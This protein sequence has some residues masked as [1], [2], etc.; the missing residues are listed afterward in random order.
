[1]QESTQSGKRINGRENNEGRT[2]KKLKNVHFP[3]YSSS[4]FFAEKN[5]QVQMLRLTGTTM[6]LSKQSSLQPLMLIL[7]FR[8]P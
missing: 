8:H 6:P 1:L 3:L 2:I 5:L 7:N 4:V